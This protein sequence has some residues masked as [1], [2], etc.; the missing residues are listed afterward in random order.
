MFIKWLI[1][2]RNHR[3]RWEE[4][5]NSKRSYPHGTYTVGRR[6]GGGWERQTKTI[7]K[8]NVRCYDSRV[9]NNFFF[10]P[11]YPR[12][13]KEVLLCQENLRKL[14]PPHTNSG[15]PV[16]VLCKCYGRKKAEDSNTGYVRLC[17]KNI[18]LNIN[19]SF[20]VFFKIMEI[21]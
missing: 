19:E 11:E 10:T 5:T 4:W 15:H 20:M 21:I 2:A 14:P 7:M 9:T 8:N 3:W 13:C 17:Y 12:G 1:W 18:K 6:G 16:Y